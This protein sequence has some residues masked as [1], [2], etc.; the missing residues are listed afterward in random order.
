MYTSTTTICTSLFLS[1]PSGWR[2]TF[3]AIPRHLRGDYFYPR[4]PGGGRLLILQPGARLFYF[5][6]R[7]PGGGR[8]RTLQDIVGHLCIS[9]HA[10]R[11]EG[12]HLNRYGAVI[13]I[14]FYPRPPGGGRPPDVGLVKADHLQFL[15][16]PS[17]WR[18]TLF[19]DLIVSKCVCISIHALRVE[20]DRKWPKSLEFPEISIHALRV[21]GDRSTSL[22]MD[23]AAMKFLSTP[24]GWRAT[25][26]CGLSGAIA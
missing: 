20:G 9:I 12:D 23:E 1:T 15:S 21:E 2:A 11:V 26:G 4:P 6:P 24:S 25:R 18:A 8:H 14:D 13:V 3:G 22:K 5:Y 7:P 16:T 19:F 10:L 17:G